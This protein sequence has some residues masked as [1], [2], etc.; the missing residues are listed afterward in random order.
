MN[1][2]SAKKFI[3]A[4]L[5]SRWPDWGTTISQADAEDWI[6]WLRP[7]EYAAAA[8][9]A[10]AHAKESIYKRPTARR[11]FDILIRSQQ[12][13]KKPVTTPGV[14]DTQVYIICTGKDASGLG[15]VGYI[16]MVITGSGIDQDPD[17]LVRIGNRDVDSFARQSGGLW[18]V[19]RGSRKE[20]IRMRHNL[21]AQAFQEALQSKTGAEVC[22][23]TP[24]PQFDEPDAETLT[25][26]DDFDEWMS[27][28][29][30]QGTDD[31]Q[32]EEV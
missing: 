7:Y 32:N 15:P 17:A 6:E 3:E 1:K 11:F 13:D 23:D 18:K 2:D 29:E 30:A 9:A 25:E 26:T 21:F 10:R 5:I 20:L 12:K 22:S 24:E 14:P 19:V 31:T 16:T 28:H 4:E 27:R 8:A